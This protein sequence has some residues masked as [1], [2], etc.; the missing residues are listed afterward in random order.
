MKSIYVDTS[1]KKFMFDL[2]VLFAKGERIKILNIEEVNKKIAEELKL[3]Y[4]KSFNMM[5]KYWQDNNLAPSFNV[6]SEQ[7][8]V[9]LI[10]PVRSATQE[11]KEKL[12]AIVNDY[13]TKGYK[14]HYPE[15][16]ANQNP[17]VNGV[18]TGGYSICFDNTVANAKAKNTILF[19]NKTSAGS[20]FDLGVTY[21]FKTLNPERKFILA[22]EIILDE[23]DFIDN[24]VKQLLAEN[25]VSID[26]IK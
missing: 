9:F 24:K 4:A 15:R 12:Y 25:K 17:V 19:Y 3:G 1:N 7:H 14:I 18:N 13:E 16:D 2:G 21:Y 11:E 5:I 26:T 10:C 23:N 20:M 8:K 22:N 6:T